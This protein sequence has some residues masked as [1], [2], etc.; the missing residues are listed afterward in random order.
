MYWPDNEPFPEQGQIRP[1]GL[2]GLAVRHPTHLLLNVD[3]RYLQPPPILNTGNRGPISHVCSPS[4]IHEHALTYLYSNPAIGCVKNA[5][6]SIG[7][8][9]KSARRVFPVSLFVISRNL[10]NISALDAEGNGDSISAAVQAERIALLTNVLAKTHRSHSMT[11]PQVHR[12]FIRSS[13]PAQVQVHRSQSHFDLGTQYHP[14]YQTSGHGHL[15]APAP[16]PLL[17]SFL[18]HSP[19][20]LSPVSTSSADLSLDEYDLHPEKSVNN[21][22]KMDGDECTAIQWRN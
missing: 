19:I 8:A 1:N 14:I 12:P 6:I 22:W 7:A 13:S 4:D 17:P 10:V 20:M 9:E 11:P 18:Q 15:H 16:A 3:S 5:T 21:I 2:V